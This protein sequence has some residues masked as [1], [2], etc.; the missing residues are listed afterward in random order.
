MRQST[1]WEKIFVMYSYGKELISRIYLE[2]RKL[3]T[4]RIN[5]PINKWGLSI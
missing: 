5:N 1:E 3:N 2:L 4:K